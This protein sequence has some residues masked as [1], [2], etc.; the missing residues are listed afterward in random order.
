MGSGA[1]TIDSVGI[2]INVYRK[3]CRE[4]ENMKRNNDSDQTMTRRLKEL[5]QKELPEGFNLQPAPVAANILDEFFISEDTLNTN[6]YDCTI[7]T[8][9]NNGSRDAYR[10][11]E[12]R[13]ESGGSKNPFA[14]NA[15]SDRRGSNSVKKENPFAGNSYR[16]LSATKTGSVDKPVDSSVADTNMNQYDS[17][18]FLGRGAY[19]VCSLCRWRRTGQLVVLKQSLCPL[20]M[21]S[22]SEAE[23]EKNEIQLLRT[24]SH[25]NIIGYLGTFAH[26]GYTHIVMDYAEGGNLHFH[27]QQRRAARAPSQ[28]TTC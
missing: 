11:P 16:S 15:S 25:R 6:E 20:K 26:K 5:V 2:E 24:L 18:K 27:I 21:L 9:S 12:S 22:E 10:Q 19:A 23:G 13:R 7:S 17:L 3:A 28:A 8:F 1:S 4:Y 14:S